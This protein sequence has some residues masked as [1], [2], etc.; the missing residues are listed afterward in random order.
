MA[1]QFYE[2]SKNHCTINFKWVTFKWHV[3][4]ISVMILKN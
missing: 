4:Y 3:N 2:Y 1:A